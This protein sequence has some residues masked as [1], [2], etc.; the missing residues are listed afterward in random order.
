MRRVTA[1]E[2][3]PSISRNYRGARVDRHFKTIDDLDRLPAPVRCPFHLTDRLAVVV[4]NPIDD[5][6]I[7]GVFFDGE[8]V[9]MTE[10]AARNC[11]DGLPSN[12]AR[13]IHAS[14]RPERLAQFIPRPRSRDRSDGSPGCRNLPK[15]EVDE[16]RGLVHRGAPRT[17]HLQRPRVTLRRRSANGSNGFAASPEATG[18]D[19]SC[20]DVEAVRHV[21]DGFVAGHERSGYR[22]P[23]S[24]P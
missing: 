19:L 23:R 16:T 10:E 7:V 22:T 13:P 1:K 5:V 8:L 12:P 3:P 20:A 15:L 6:V 2:W 18:E 21:L 17:H 24:D 11:R 9:R 4:M 14:P